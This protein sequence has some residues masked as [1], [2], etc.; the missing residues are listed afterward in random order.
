MS[1]INYVAKALKH[2]KRI[3]F[4]SLKYN[5]RGMKIRGIRN[6]THHKLIL[7]WYKKDK[8]SIQNN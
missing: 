1:S 3:H 4:L 8:Y 6:A 5:S 7:I 2:M